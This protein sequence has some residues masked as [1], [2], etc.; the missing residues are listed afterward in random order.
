MNENRNEMPPQH[1]LDAMSEQLQAKNREIIARV[2]ANIDKG[3]TE[4]SAV[5]FELAILAMQLENLT[6]I[7]LAT[8]E[9]QPLIEVPR[10]G[11]TDIKNG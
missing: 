4:E 1:I 9:E 5:L 7:V 8:Q 10:I 3:T 6:A 11:I 2:Q